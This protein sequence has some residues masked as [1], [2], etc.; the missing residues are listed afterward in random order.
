MTKEYYWKVFLKTSVS[1]EDRKYREIIR[2]FKP[3]D[4]FN[5]PQDYTSKTVG[6]LNFEN[7]NTVPF[8]KEHI[9]TTQFFSKPNSCIISP[10]WIYGPTFRLPYNF[11]TNREHAWLNV[12]FKYFSTYP[13]ELSDARLVIELNHNKGQYIEKRRNWD[14]KNQPFLVNQWNDFS[15]DYLTPYPLSEQKDILTIYVY[16]PGSKPIYIDDFKVEAYERNW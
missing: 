13:I 8:K 5:N 11:V 4:V 1:A 15:V 7:V 3:V 12:S 9:D 14:L 16:V 10:E 6:F 2:D